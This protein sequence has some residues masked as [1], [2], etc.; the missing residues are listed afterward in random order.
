[1]QTDKKRIRIKIPVL[2]PVILVILL[3]FSILGAFWL[4]RHNDIDKVQMKIEGASLFYDEYIRT[5]SSLMS[6]MLDLIKGNSDLKN[7][8]LA[9]DR[10]K[11]LELAKP[12]FEN[13]H[14]KCKVTHMYFHSPDRTCFLRVHNPAKYGDF[15]TR[16]TMDL[17]EEHQQP[18]SG[19]EFGPY[20]TYTLRVVHPWLIDGELSG[21][22]EIGE[23]VEEILPVL[24]NVFGVELFITIDKYY[25]NR[26]DWE[27][28]MRI[29]G[30]KN[31]NWDMFSKIVIVNS[32][33][34]NLSEESLKGIGGI[35]EGHKKSSHEKSLFDVVIKRRSYKGGFVHLVDAGH[36]YVGDII[37]MKD[38]TQV[39][40]SL[41]LFSIILTF[42]CIIV[43]AAL[44]TL[45]CA[46]IRRIE[47]GAS[48]T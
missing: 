16:P 17:A 22:V 12:I 32:T 26:A 43:G 39:K 19:V 25:L 1:M 29:M 5:H 24:K 11:L 45:F 4:Q 37:V 23:E 27:E 9:K 48:S 46:Y 18:A 44:W 41:K 13:L 38:I 2:A 10:D 33:L 35:L 7:A 14:S 6:A 8:W 47:S 3:S 42:V 20:G 40:S 28:G 31:A 21:Y 36:L 34:E 15:I 30:R